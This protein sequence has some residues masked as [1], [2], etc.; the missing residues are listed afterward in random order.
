MTQKEKVDLWLKKNEQKRKLREL[1]EQVLVY[2]EWINALTWNEKG[3]V[4][5][6]RDGADLNELGVF[7]VWAFVDAVNAL[8]QD[9]IGLGVD[10][11]FTPSKRKW[12]FLAGTTIYYS[13]DEGEMPPEFVVL[14][15]KNKKKGA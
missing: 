11:G 14:S 3:E 15:A 6:D 13:R 10:F 9:N 1:K 8:I 2:L 7:S 5:K 12:Y 4:V